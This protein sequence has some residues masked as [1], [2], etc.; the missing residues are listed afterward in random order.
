VVRLVRVGLPDSLV[1]APGRALPGVVTLRVTDGAGQPIAGARIRWT[2]AGLNGRVEDETQLTGPDGLA[3]AKWILGTRASDTQHVVV[4]ARTTRSMGA[5]DLLARAQ[6]VEVAEL[7]FVLDTNVAKLGVPHQ[8]DVEAVDPFGNVFVPDFIAFASLDTGVVAVDSTG[9]LTAKR[10]GSARVAAVSG[11]FADTGWV[12]VVQ[13][14]RT[15]LVDLDSVAFTAVG[16]T[17]V[18]TVSLLDDQGLPVADSLPLVSVGDTAVAQVLPGDPVRVRSRSNGS[19]AF[20][21]SVPEATRAVP[22]TV[23]QEPDSVEA[24]AGWATPILSLQRDS[25]IPVTCRVFDRNGYEAPITPTVAASLGGRWSGT[26]CDQL[27]VRSS[28]FDTLRFRAG[29]AEADIPAI[30]AVRPVV[31]PSLGELLQ[32]DSLPSNTGPWA[33]TA[34]TSAQGEI[35]VY[36]TAY[37]IVPDSSGQGQ[38]SLHRLVSLDGVSFRYDGLVLAHDSAACSP[39]GSGI[40]SID[41]VP[42]ADAAGWRM[43][44]SSG[45]F[46]CYGW[47]VY[48]AVSSDGRNWSREPGVRLGNGGSLTPTPPDSSPW[49]V[50]EGM[51]TERLASGEWRMIVG[52]YEHLTP[53]EDKFQI[54]AWHSFD[55]L[56][57]TYVGPV[58]TTR[59]LPPTGQRS[60]YSPTIRQFAPGLWRMLFTA[61]D[62]NVPG[63]RSRVW[64]AVSTD[65]QAWQLEGE[66]LGGV[67]RDYFY[68]SLV[69]ERLVTISD[70]DGLL[71]TRRLYSARVEMP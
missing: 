14:V 69:G 28:G 30:L 13:L 54:V 17:H 40:E 9:T 36:Y 10:R 42:R 27:R 8:L 43:Y 33:P 44:Y 1:G 19:T 62:R 57:W 66:I 38:G 49:P 67:G 20:V 21:A 51:V 45:S 6:P 3:M 70:P 65:K 47:Q 56:S 31:T 29:A 32:V 71:S 16:D 35:E 22:V 39:N 50:G 52:G 46:G 68:A 48:S 15:I 59:E 60:V 5:T 37:R 34:R 63:G 18:V 61:D 24:V 64:S 55:Q 4:E 23:T 53:P 12:S 41:I 58:F 11:G 26:V 25:I 2:V 7:R